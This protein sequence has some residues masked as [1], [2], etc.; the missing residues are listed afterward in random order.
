MNQHITVVKSLVQLNLI[1][2]IQQHSQ[3]YIS[4][5]KCIHWFHIF[6]SHFIVLYAVSKTVLK[7]KCVAKKF[8]KSDIFLSISLVLFIKLCVIPHDCN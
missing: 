3:K 2:E 5:P 4:V 8:A 7:H 1:T 6:A